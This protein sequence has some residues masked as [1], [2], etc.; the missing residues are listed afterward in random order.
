MQKCDYIVKSYSS[1][2]F[3]ACLLFLVLQPYFVWHLPSMI[4]LLIFS[5]PAVLSLRHIDFCRKNHFFF[6]LCILLFGNIV[7]G[8]N[9]IYSVYLLSFSVVP[10]IKRD[11]AEKVY[12]CFKI[13]ISYVLLLSL[14]EWILYLLGFSLPNYIIDPLTEMK[15]YNYIV[16]LPFSVVPNFI[17]D[18]YRFHGCFD[19]PGV[20]GTIALLLLYIEDY[21]LKD[22]KNIII[23]IAG[24][25]SF[26]FFFILG[27]F[28]Y[29]TIKLFYKNPLYIFIFI[30][31]IAV[32]YHYTKDNEVLSELVYARLEWDSSSNSFVGDSRATDYFKSYYESVKGTWGYY[33]G[34]GQDEL[35]Y[36]NDGGYGYRN[37]VLRYGAIFCG[38]YVLFFI[39]Y[40]YSQ[41]LSRL[42]F[43]IF[44]IMLCATLYQRPN[45]IDA[46]FLF[47][48]TQYI[49]NHCPL[50]IS[51]R[52]NH[53]G[54]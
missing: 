12:R 19:E 48:F 50:Y 40:A 34:V 9:L 31:A 15:D 17:L 46:T 37:A 29:L 30:F 43:I 23:L 41:K 4:K 27:T 42:S 20:V 36:H 24:I 10:F 3:V 11:Y 14:I 18:S 35:A 38:L 45:M 22:Y 5:L 53:Y 44:C 54:H 2:L 32:F 21:N 28:I 52:A 51:N 39:V 7:Q 13:I 1:A 26:S 49:N 6:F 16:N 47:L 8:N 33:F 25:C